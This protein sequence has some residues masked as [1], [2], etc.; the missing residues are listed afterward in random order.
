M[1]ERVKLELENMESAGI[2]NGTFDTAK[3]NIKLYLQPGAEAMIIV[4]I[5]DNAKAF[6]YQVAQTY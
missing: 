5:I 4:T 2:F 1:V 3:L 6:T